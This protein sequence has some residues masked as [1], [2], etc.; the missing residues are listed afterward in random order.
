[1]KQ[2][3][4]LLSI[5]LLGA[6]AMDQRSSGP[7]ASPLMTDTLLNTGCGDL[8]DDYETFSLLD[9]EGRRQML[10]NL[11]GIWGI[12]HDHCGQLRLALLL[13]HPEQSDK[14]RQKALKLLKGL[15]SGEELRDPGA[16][17]LAKFMGDQLQQIRAQKLK[18]L[19]LR[20][21]LKA[22]QAISRQLSA[23]L[24]T[25]QTQIQQLKNIE[26]NINEKERYIITPST[27]N[28]TPDS[29]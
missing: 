3:L 2:N 29:P 10:K 15:L 28:A 14:D 4:L 7:P 24:A 1:M 5:L 8:L 27:D 21:Q 26:Q 11:S 12:T 13:S 18:T 17:R 16:H 6:C 20:H 23:E 19:E 22:Q 25:L 9:K